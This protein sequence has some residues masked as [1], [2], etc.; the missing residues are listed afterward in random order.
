MINQQKKKSLPL[1]NH[2]LIP[3]KFYQ[4]KLKSGVGYSMLDAH[5]NQCIDRNI[6]VYKRLASK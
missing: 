3:S 2:A 1:I 6:D 5:I 4:K